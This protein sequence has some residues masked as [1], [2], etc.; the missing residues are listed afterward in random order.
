MSR[1]KKAESDQLSAVRSARENRY[2]ERPPAKIAESTVERLIRAGVDPHVARVDLELVKELTRNDTQWSLEQ[3]ELAELEYKRVLTLL[4]W[5]PGLPHPIVPI[6]LVDE[7]WHHHILDSRAY[8][9]DMQ[10]VLGEYLHHFPYLG[11]RTEESFR[12]KM[13]AF[14]RS[15]Q[16]YEQTFGEPLVDSRWYSERSSSE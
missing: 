13:E 11:F 5:N 12:L 3:T 14:E 2:F 15:C 6:R 7:I 4:R 10:Q 8:H 1:T 16:L 9:A